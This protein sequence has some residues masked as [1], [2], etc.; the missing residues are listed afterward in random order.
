MLNQNSHRT[1]HKKF[2]FQNKTGTN[3]HIQKII[4]KK[5]TTD[6][7]NQ[8]KKGKFKSVK[9]RYFSNLI[10]FFRYQKEYLK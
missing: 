1:K 3:D 2:R 5:A 10:S 4:K 9:M 6:I 7:K 8:N